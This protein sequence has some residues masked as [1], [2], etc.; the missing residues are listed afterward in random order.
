MK[1]LILIAATLASPTLYAWDGS[2]EL[3]G[4]LQ[5]GNSP[6]E[7]A[8]AEIS[9]KT[10]IGLN[11][12]ELQIGG[13]RERSGQ[14]KTL[15]NEQYSANG[16]YNHSF[17]EGDTAYFYAAPH[18]RY[19]RFAYLIETYTLTTG[20]GREWS[21]PI[22]E[23]PDADPISQFRVQ[24]GVGYRQSRRSDDTHSAEAIFLLDSQGTWRIND[25]LSFEG[26]ISVETGAS[27]TQTLA[28]IALRNRLSER[29]ALKVSG[30]VDYISPVAENKK[31][32]D[33][34]VSLSLLYDF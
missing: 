14:V 30:E 32:T 27:V 7:Q 1:T 4:L 8:K 34:V 15:T 9:T 13:L 19:N 21:W 16:Q 2:V 6:L 29:L 5:S 12:Y 33:T 25:N 26:N 17:N 24:A 11:Q 28:E 23:Q 31:N 18:Y 20:L 10:K 3:G 22:A